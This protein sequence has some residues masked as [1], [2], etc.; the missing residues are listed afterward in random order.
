MTIENR[1]MI[2]Y[3]YYFAHWIHSVTTKPMLQ[4]SHWAS[5]AA[6]IFLWVSETSPIFV[7]GSPLKANVYTTCSNMRRKQKEQERKQWCGYYA[8]CRILKND[9]QLV[10]DPI[11]SIL[12]IFKALHAQIPATGDDI[13]YFDTWL[14]WEKGMTLFLRFIMT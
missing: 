8:R 9:M 5:P 2:S 4:L 3:Y 13:Q 11:P 12:H 14:K 7:M 6:R 1:K 10:Q